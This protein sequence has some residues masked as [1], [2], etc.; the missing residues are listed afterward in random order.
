MKQNTIIIAVTI[1]LIGGVVGY[2]IA[3]G[4]TYEM[5]DMMHQGM[6][7]GR[8][9]DEA[10]TNTISGMEHSMMM[11]ESER[12]FIE[13]MIP[14][15]QE[16]VDT[17]QQVI[18]RGGSTP[19]IKALAEN[20]VMAQEKEIAAMKQWYQEWYGVEYIQQADE[21]QPMMRELAGLSGA[22]LDTRFLEDMIM[23]H[24]GAMMMARSVQPYIEHS[25]VTDLA[26]AIAKT[27]S[28]EIQLMEQLLRD[29]E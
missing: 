6:D 10:Q 20:I 29:I 12:A 26:N 23:H 25:E 28:A 24:M 18:E 5:D 2:L 13:R 9:F 7:H 14:H 1:L 19:E 3:A 21:Y 16:A 17:A 11:V 4:D 22:A 8:D 15:H 27:Q